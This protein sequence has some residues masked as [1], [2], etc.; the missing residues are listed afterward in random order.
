MGVDEPSSGAAPVVTAASSTGGVVV[1]VVEVV[2]VVVSV[3]E[4]VEVVDVVRGATVMTSWGGVEDSRLR[5]RVPSALADHTARATGPSPVTGGSTSISYQLP[6]ATGPNDPVLAPSINGRDSQV[7]ASVQVVEDTPRTSPPVSALS[8]CYSRRTA[9]VP[10]P[11][12]TPET[13][14]RMNNSLRGEPSTHIACRRRSWST[15]AMHRR[16]RGR[17]AGNA[18]PRSPQRP[19]WAPAPWPEAGQLARL[20]R[21][22][23]DLVDP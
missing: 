22:V 18:A 16:A 2:E 7:I 9:E 12:P 8:R 21:S 1:A 23:Q 20:G 15:A 11:V 5:H 4:V 3:V 6:F 10:V 17:W 19:W 14:N 13:S